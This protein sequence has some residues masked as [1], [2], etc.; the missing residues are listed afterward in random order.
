VFRIIVLVIIW[1]ILV[2]FQI[3]ALAVLNSDFCD[4]F[5]CRMNRTGWFAI[6]A[7][8]FF[9][10]VGICMCFA[11]SYEDEKYPSEPSTTHG[12]AVELVEPSHGQSTDFVPEDIHN[13]IGDAQEIQAVDFTVIGS[14]APAAVA[15]ADN[16]GRDEYVTGGQPIPAMAIIVEDNASGAVP[17]VSAKQ[18]EG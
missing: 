17:I 16:S 3:S 8:G 10:M 2:P 1:G 13:G 18:I 6:L 4:A 12:G 14:V 7:F 15:F 5:A 11:R 9:L